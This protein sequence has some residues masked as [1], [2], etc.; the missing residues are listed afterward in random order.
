MTRLPHRTRP[1]LAVLAAL[2]ATVSATAAAQAPP[3]AAAPAGED[4]LE[5]IAPA[6]VGIEAV[7]RTEMSMGG[8]GSDEEGNVEMV[9]AVVDP[10]GLIMVWNSRISS[11]RIGEVL[12]VMG[13][14][15]EGFEIKLTP[16]RFDVAV[17]GRG[18]RLPAFLAASDERL[19]VAFLQLE[20]PP[21]EPLPAI[22]LAAAAEP[23]VGGPVYAVSRLNQ[24][25]D[26]APYFETGLVVGELV[27]PRRAWILEGEL[28]AMGLPLFDAAGRPVGV[29]ATVLSSA[30][31]EDGGVP[32]M[33]GL[34][35]ESGKT[36]GPL[37]GFLLPTEPV[38]RAVELSK[39]RAQEMLRQRAE[40][41]E[42]GGEGAGDEGTGDE[43]TGEGGTAE[44]GEEAEV[45][46][47]P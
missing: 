27:K 3:P 14:A 32:G 37:G 39:A 21:A 15:G 40:A 46:P 31:K 42:S 5:R 28:T 18:D 47:G 26:R 9:G 19:D 23:A 1:A 30:G 12:E 22:D 29:L 45:A 16:V 25:F 6:I 13:R 2:A 44:P 11:A 34:F 17:P 41:A 35:G 8:Q 10:G 4:L 38:A 20:S 24:S 33:G 7:I 43:G 36:L